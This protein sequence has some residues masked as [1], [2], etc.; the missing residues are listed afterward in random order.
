LRRFAGEQSGLTN[1]EKNMQLL[2]IA[3]ASWLLVFS[4]SAFSQATVNSLFQTDVADVTNQEIVVLEVNY[5][6]GNDSPVH[7]H[8]AHT[9]VYVLEGSVIMAVAGGEPQTLGPGDVFYE[10]PDD[11]HSVSR[12]ASATE[13]AKIL[14]FFL[15]EKGAASTEPAD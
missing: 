1:L 13:P 7:R 3:I 6:A 2:R 14:V 15:K 11:I 9:I 8:N 10:S 12:N 4:S 5:P